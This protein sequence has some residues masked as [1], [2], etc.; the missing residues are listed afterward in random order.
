M[1]ELYLRF[2]RTCTGA[3]A[4]VRAALLTDPHTLGWLASGVHVCR[5]VGCRQ[6]RTKKGQSVMQVIRV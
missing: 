2:T 3:A 5:M 6:G 4:I 1:H